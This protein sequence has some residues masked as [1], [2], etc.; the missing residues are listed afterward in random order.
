MD[1]YSNISKYAKMNKYNEVNMITDLV[2]YVVD[3]KLP[4]S[5]NSEY[6]SI[7]KKG[8]DVYVNN[9]NQSKVKLNAE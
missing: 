8:G 6:V 9:L 1:D 3:G 2:N 5:S 7:I 4:E